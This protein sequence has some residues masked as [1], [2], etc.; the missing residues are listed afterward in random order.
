MTDNIADMLTRIRNALL[1]KQEQVVVPYSKLKEGVAKLLCREG[2]LRGVEVAG[3]KTK[4]SLVLRLKYL[5]DGSP[6]ITNLK[7]ISHLSRRVYSGF[8]DLKPFRSGMGVRILTTSKGILT[9]EEARQKKLGGEVL[10]EVW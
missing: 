5:A 7:K 8:E 1:M 10:L 6:V 2:F 4:K 9:D 3:E